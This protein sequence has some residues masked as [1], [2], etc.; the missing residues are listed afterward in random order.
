ARG[1]LRHPLDEVAALLND[2][3]RA[4][5]RRPLVLAVDV[6]SGIGA[7]SGQVIGACVQA[8][9]TAALGAVKAGTLRFPAA[10]CVGRLLC[11]SIGLPP[12]SVGVQDPRV[13]DEA[14][15]ASLVPK[16]PLSAHKG[17]LGKVL[18]VGGSRQYL[19]APLLS[20]LAAARSGCGLVALAGSAALQQ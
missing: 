3:R 8:D 14:S 16:R 13:L 4:E 20:A 12:D 7:D 2:A 1:A 9:V 5:R 10:E 6:P 17:S 19:G 15:V 11:L 18:V